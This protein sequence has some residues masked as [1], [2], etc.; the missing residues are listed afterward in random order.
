MEFF[1]IQPYLIA[2][3]PLLFLILVA[4]K[5]VQPC[6]YG[7]LSVLSGLV[8]IPFSVLAL[9]HNES[10]WKP[11]LHGLADLGGKRSAP[12]AVHPP[13]GRTGG[14]NV[15]G[16]KAGV[17]DHPNAGLAAFRRH[18]L[19]DLARHLQKGGAEKP[20]NPVVP[21]GALQLGSQEILQG[22]AA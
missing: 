21:A 11:G 10:Y 8:C 2:D 4:A 5:V 20:G 14:L 22:T 17:A 7:R 13:L 1:K 16:V 6:K 9:L 15:H 3:I 12:F 19:Q 18:P